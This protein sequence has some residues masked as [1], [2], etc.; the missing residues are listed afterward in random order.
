MICRASAATLTTTTPLSLRCHETAQTAGARLHEAMRG[1]LG[2]WFRRRKA[3]VSAACQ[4]ADFGS[5]LR[6]LHSRG[7]RGSKPFG[8]W[9]A[10]YRTS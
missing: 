6:D 2:G 10:M 4:I 9:S 7:A 8:L 3:V 5:R 1:S